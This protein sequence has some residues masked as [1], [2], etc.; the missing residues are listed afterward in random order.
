MAFLVDSSILRYSEDLTCDETGKYL[1]SSRS[2]CT[3]ILDKNDDVKT[4]VKAYTL[5]RKYYSHKD[6]P[7]FQRTIYELHNKENVHPICMI[8]YEWRGEKTELVFTPHGNQKNADRPYIRSKKELI[9]QLKTSQRSAAQKVMNDIY[10]KE[11]GVNKQS[12]SSVPR[13]TSQVY[14]H[15]MAK[16]SASDF[17]ELL[18]LNLKGEFMKSVE[19]RHVKS[20]GSMPRRV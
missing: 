3:V 7:N 12:F 19:F 15:N 17:S 20:K 18:K 6:T 13:D 11:G 2:K 1:K 10:G 8:R 14:R 16:G 4:E 5:V 9:E